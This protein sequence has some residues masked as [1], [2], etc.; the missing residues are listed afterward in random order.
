[1]MSTIYDLALAR[2]LRPQTAVPAGCKGPACPAFAVCQGR[3]A[4]ETAAP[5]APARVRRPPA[6]TLQ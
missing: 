3:C 6:R 2:A 5:S 4:R 1:M